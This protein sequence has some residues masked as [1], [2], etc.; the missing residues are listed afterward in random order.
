MVF[1]SDTVTIKGRDLDHLFDCIEREKVNRI[2]EAGQIDS[3]AIDP[4]E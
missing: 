2:V 3:I 4:R 1:T